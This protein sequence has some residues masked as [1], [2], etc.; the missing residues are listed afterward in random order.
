MKFKKKKIKGCILNVKA[1]EVYRYAL[2]L[3]KCRQQGFMTVVKMWLNGGWQRISRWRWGQQGLA[4]F[5]TVEAGVD[6]KGQWLG[7][8]SRAWVAECSCLEARDNRTES[9]G[10]PWGWIR[11]VKGKR[12][13]SA[14]RAASS[15]LIVGWARCMTPLTAGSRQCG[16]VGA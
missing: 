10:H 7:Q 2:C 3:S 8:N 11:S 16:H 12:V 5:S 9:V 4:R 14:T 15:S 6:C 13:F 1:R